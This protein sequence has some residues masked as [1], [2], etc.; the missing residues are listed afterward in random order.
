MGIEQDDEIELAT[1]SGAIRVRANLTELGRPGVVHM[2][3]GAP[4]ADV[5]LLLD[6][7]YLDPVSGFPGFKA[8]LCAV[9]KVEPESQPR[10]LVPTRP[11]SPTRPGVRGGEGRAVSHAFHLDVERCTGCFA[12]AVACMDQ[13]DLE[14]RDEPTAW[15]QVFAV[16]TGA[17][18]DAHL[19]YVSLACMHCEDAPC[20][21]ACPTGAIGREDGTQ[22]VGVDA[23]L[24]IGCHSCSI[25]CPFGVPRFGTDG[26][27]AKCDLCSERLKSRPG[28]GLRA[29]LPHGGAAPGQP[30]PARPERRAKGGR[31]AGRRELVGRPGQRAAELAAAGRRPYLSIRSAST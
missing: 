21:L 28:A 9:R 16:E 20:L 11:S 3:H 22:V 5:N 12:C 8:L 27:M 7:D 15:R 4:E 18:P 17:F 1:P 25:A 13:N 10:V 14:V 23:D 19:R 26:K 29:R 31:E 30:Q 2:Y 24:C 6:P